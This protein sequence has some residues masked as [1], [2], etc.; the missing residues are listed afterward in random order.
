MWRAHLPA[1]LLLLFGGWCGSFQWGASSTASSVSALLLLGL[2]AWGAASDTDPLRLGNRGRILLWLFLG[3]VLASTLRSPFPRAGLT[4]TALLPAFLLLPSVV[5]RCWHEKGLRRQ[6]S[7]SVCWVVAGLALGSLGIWLQTRELSMAAVGPF[8][9]RLLLAGFFLPFLPWTLGLSLGRDR[10]LRRSAAVAFCLSGLAILASRSILG[11]GGL[12]LVALCGLILRG[13]HRLSRGLVATFMSTLS[14]IVLWRSGRVSGLGLG[15]D[16]SWLARWTYWEGGVRGWMERPFFGW[17]LGSTPWTLGADLVPRPGINPSGEVV[18]DLHS[19]PLQLLRELGGIGAALGG[20]L[21]VV[22]LWRRWSDRRLDEGGGTRS[23]RWALLGLLVAGG[24]LSVAVTLGSSAIWVGLAV[25]AGC[26]QL[27]ERDDGEELLS[28]DRPPH[29][30]WRAYAVSAAICLAPSLLATAYYD[31]AIRASVCSERLDGATQ[32]IQLLHRAVALDPAMPLYRIRLAALK[33]DSEWTPSSR[34]AIS[35][36]WLVLASQRQGGERL[37]AIERASASDTVG[38][39]APFLNV[40][41]DPSNPQVGLWAARAVL[42]EP[43]LIAS[44]LFDRRGLRTL[45][46]GGVRNWPGVE[47]GLREALSEELMLRS[48]SAEATGKLVVLW[49]DPGEPS[50]SLHLFRRK[51]WPLEVLAITIDLDLA[52]RINIPSAASHRGTER[53]AF[54][55]P[56]QVD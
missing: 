2:V 3:S 44:P 54:S 51:P 46:A 11:A 29:W 23:Q 31:A 10:A 14:V 47:S 27:G 37:Q 35:Q 16:T 48:G 52:E 6:G 22:Y 18:G 15:T 33:G 38:W 8:G 4:G 53:T 32:S 28:E 56:L 13:N 12:L 49:D 20:G 30:I 41:E 24:Y 43:R 36:L 25:L 21:V 7:L 17:G 9:N 26:A 55:S 39:G 40:Q 45:A 50:P 34:F 19:V 42:L 1:V 5:Q